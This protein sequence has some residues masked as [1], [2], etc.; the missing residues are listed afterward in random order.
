LRRKDARLE[1]ADLEALSSD[2]REAV[3]LA[4]NVDRLVGE[5]E[6]LRPAWERLDGAAG[7]GDGAARE[8]ARLEA[9]V[10]SLSKRLHTTSAALLD[11]N[12]RLAQLPLLEAEAEARR[13]E[14]VWLVG[15]RAGLEERIASLE[16][17][18]AA[19]R[20]PANDG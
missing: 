20:Q 7:D 11:A 18:L 14:S 15:E 17:Q 9:E 4:H 6:E 16:A 2:P 8:I 1:P 5:L 13:E 12:Q 19:A 3:A 10:A